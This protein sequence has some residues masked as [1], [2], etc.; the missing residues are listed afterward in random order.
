MFIHNIN[1]IIVSIGPLSIHWYGLV[2]VIGFLLAYWWLNHLAK[3]G[4]IRNLTPERVETLTIWLIVGVVAGGRLF[5]YIFW[6]PQVWLEDP[7]Q[8]LR[9]WEGG[10]AFHGGI[11]GVALVTVIYCRKH[12]IPLYELA[13]ALTMPAAFTLFLGRIANFVNGELYGKIADVAWCVNFNSEINPETGARVCRHP[14][15]LYEAVKNLI[16]FCTLLTIHNKEHHKPGTLTW[17]FIA[18][19]GLLRTIV[20]VWRDDQPVIGPFSIGQVLSILM[21][22]LGT[23]MLIIMNTTT[24]NR[25]TRT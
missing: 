18:A 24:N 1:P 17:T 15:Q 22:L 25:G 21:F 2:Y 12:R 20:N 23:T 3:Q 6:Q 4:A 13:D 14:S 7:L 9:I 8:I 10:M 11:I 5:E 19:Y 16:I